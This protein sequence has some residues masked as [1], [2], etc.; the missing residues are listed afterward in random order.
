[1][2]QHPE[3]IRRV[4]FSDLEYFGYRFF[5]FLTLFLPGEGGG[6]GGDGGG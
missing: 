2:A 5:S 6:D 3:R 1:M 4:D